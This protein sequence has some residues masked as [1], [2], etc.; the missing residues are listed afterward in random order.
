MAVSSTRVADIFKTA[1]RLIN[2]NRAFASGCYSSFPQ[3]NVIYPMYVVEFEG[4]S[5]AWNTQGFMAKI[6]PYQVQCYANTMKSLDEITGE[7]EKILIDNKN[8]LRE[9]GL[10][11]LRITQSNTDHSVVNDKTIHA[12]MVTFDGEWVG[13]R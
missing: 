2:D 11:Q 1:R 3:T 5:S 4:D 13:E 10:A 6:M 8:I 9:S 7:V 12:R